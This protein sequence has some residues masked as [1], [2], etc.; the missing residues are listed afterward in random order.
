MAWSYDRLW[1][2]L[3]QRKMKRTQLKE[4]AHI[5]SVALAKMGKNQP[6]TMESLGKICTALDCR[7]EDIVEFI[8]NEKAGDADEDHAI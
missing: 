8:P 2:M 5:S 7:I 3:I 6:I 1:I 4:A